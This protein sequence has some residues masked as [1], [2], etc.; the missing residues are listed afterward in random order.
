MSGDSCRADNY[1][2]YWIEA[3]QQPVAPEAA[4]EALGEAS[5]KETQNEHSQAC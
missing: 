2:D 4:L 1:S 3:A 5:S